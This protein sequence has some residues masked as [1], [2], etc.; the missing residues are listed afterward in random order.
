[1]SDNFKKNV[2]I[3]LIDA[4]R[5]KNLS[6]YGYQKETDNNLKAVAEEG[7]VFKNFFP[8]SNSTAPSLMS[9]FTGRHPYR[10]GI[11][12]QFPYTT[13]EE[14]EKMYQE[15]K[16][17]LPSFLR[18]KGYETIAIDWIGM[19]F[20]DGF[21]Y[22]KEREDW[23]GESKVSTEFS[24]AKD[25]MNLAISKIK[26]AKEPFFLFIHFWD[27]HFPFLTTE[28]NETEEKSI[29]EALKEIKSDSQKEFYRK[30]IQAEGN[31]TYSVNGMIRKYDAAIKEVDNQIG[32][33]YKYLKEN[34][35]WDNTIFLVLGDH[36]VNLTEHGI[37]F[38]SSSLFEDTIHAPFVAH[39][40]GFGKK[41]VEGF[42]QNQDIAPTVL[43]LLGEKIENS[44]QFDGKSMINL[45]KNNEEIR[46]KV[47]F[48]D[49]LSEIVKGVRTKDRK[50]ILASN[51]KCHLCKAVHHKEKEEYDLEKD[52][53]E[54][55]NVYS[56]QSS[57]EQH[58]I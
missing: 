31:K 35:L 8:G 44:E 38:S 24:P 17:W 2:V 36:G 29:E 19:F 3:I 12:H 26:E 45:I 13:E 53:N 6:L 55:K 30:R 11:I 50:L 18:E 7:I 52:P 21:D 58:I 48:S 15:R 33:L 27:T 54:M 25:T 42:I 32:K 37:Y 40:P 14:V 57:L 39:L 5:P 16:F 34:N 47:F 10:H 1:M 51:P 28:F 56:G 23:Q 46:D 20:E 49:G 43:D 22:Y 9:I 4:F 41:E